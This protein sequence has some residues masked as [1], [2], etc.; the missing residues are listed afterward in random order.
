MTTS[1]LAETSSEG[2]RWQPLG[3]TENAR[4]ESPCRWR[5]GNDGELN[6]RG[7]SNQRDVGRT[8]NQ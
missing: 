1:Q 3:G 4:T 6:W 8:V 2:W 7:L 5:R